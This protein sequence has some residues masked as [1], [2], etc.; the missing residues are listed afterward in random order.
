MPVSEAMEYLFAAGGDE[1]NLET[2][3]VFSESKTK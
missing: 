2:I 1:F 3:K